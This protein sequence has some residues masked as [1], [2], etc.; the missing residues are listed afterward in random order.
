[1]AVPPYIG[2]KTKYADTMDDY[3]TAP[4]VTR[5]FVELVMCGGSKRK[6]ATLS[7]A[8]F[9]EPAC[10]RGH[11]MRTL[12]E[13]SSRVTGA[14]V[15]GYGS[16]LVIDYLV[17]PHLKTSFKIT[18]PPFALAEKFFHKMYAESAL[19][20]GLFAK[21]LWMENPGRYERIFAITPPNVIAVLSKRMPGE[22]KRIIRTGSPYLSHAWFWWDKRRPTI[23]TQLQWLPP[24]TQ[25]R[26][27][28][29]SDYE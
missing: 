2:R 1:M 4:W 16:N 18:N 8:T 17:Q 3:P 29:G 6:L 20:V 10:G 19:G 13:Y 28:R 27:E 5:A 22:G 21:T 24:D 23:E 11:M 15:V 25:Q 14:D 7:N 12:A 26:F 9:H